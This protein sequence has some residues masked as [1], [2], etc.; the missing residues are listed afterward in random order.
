MAGSSKDKER[1]AGIGQLDQNSSW[2]RELAD[3]RDMGEKPSTTS[4]SL[5][6]Q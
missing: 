1:V 4:T 5:E 3:S 6:R 2:V